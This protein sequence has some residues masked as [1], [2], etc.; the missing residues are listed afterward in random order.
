MK[1]GEVSR[2]VSLK[3]SPRGVERNFRETFFEDQDRLLWPETTSVPFITRGPLSSYAQTN[4]DA[5][6]LGNQ[7]VR[8]TEREGLLSEFQIDSGFFREE[9]QK[10]KKK[11]GRRCGKEWISYQSVGIWLGLM[12]TDPWPIP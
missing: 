11:E 4:Y 6:Y 3:S 9:E 8:E 10:K 5:P 2:E 1:R 7:R 12:D